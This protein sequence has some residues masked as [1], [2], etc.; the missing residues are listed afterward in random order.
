MSDHNLPAYIDIDGRAYDQPYSTLTRQTSNSPYLD[1]LPRL[2]V[3]MSPISAGSSTTRLPSWDFNAGQ[4]SS[5][6]LSTPSEHEAFVAQTGAMSIDDSSQIDLTEGTAESWGFKE[7]QSLAITTAQP[8]TP[9]EIS[10]APR[11]SDE[12]KYLDAYWKGIHSYWP[13]IH[14]PTFA[15]HCT[16][17]LLKAAM[18]AL[19]AHALDEA[20]HK[21]NARSMHE[22]CVKVLKKVRSS[23]R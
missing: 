10:S 7:R 14:R 8:I 3:S 18:L 1:M 5:G 2:P 22:K 15:L 11:L 6:F 17:P 21:R 13:I 16:S 12:K 23:S 20:T 9:S 19:G 4:S